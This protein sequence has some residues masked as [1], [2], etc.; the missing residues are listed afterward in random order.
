SASVPSGTRRAQAQPS[1]QPRS[2]RG[3]LGMPV[4]AVVQ[5]PRPESSQSLAERK[6]ARHR[7]PAPAAAL[8]RAALSSVWPR[9][10][11]P[12][13]FGGGIGE[14]AFLRGYL[15]QLL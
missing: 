14:C 3:T 15:R 7:S 5:L 13:A 4:G 10:G 1:L 6:A 12:A 11:S 9:I 2:G 8:C